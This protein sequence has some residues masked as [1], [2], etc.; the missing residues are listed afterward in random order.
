MKERTAHVLIRGTTI[1]LAA[2]AV[3]QVAFAGS[4]L[5]GH[6]PVL[7]WHLVTGMAMV[8]VAHL[9]AGAV[10]LPGRRERPRV[11]LIAGLVLPLVVAGQGALGMGRVLG[12]HVPLGGLPVV[13]VFPP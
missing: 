12:L 7:R 1:A 8:A 4:F 6:Y 13:G 2:L 5:S 10:L 11:V 9:Q 3:A